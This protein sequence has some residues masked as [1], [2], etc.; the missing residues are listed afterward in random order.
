MTSSLKRFRMQTFRENNR[1][2]G[3][4]QSSSETSDDED[5]NRSASIKRRHRQE[6]A[7]AERENREHTSALLELRDMEDELNTLRSL[8]AEQAATIETMRTRYEAPELHDITE[9]GRY[10]LSEALERLEEYRKQTKDMIHRVDTTRTDVSL[11]HKFLLSI[12][13]SISI[14]YT[15]RLHIR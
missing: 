1:I 15:L 8:F 13:I 4:D 5:D 2:L 11:S 10:F 14:R 12:F 6:L 7:Q 3:D 9:N